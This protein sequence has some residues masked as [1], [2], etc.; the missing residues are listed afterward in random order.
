LPHTAPSELKGCTFAHWGQK[1]HKSGRV[2]GYYGYALHALIRVPDLLKDQRGPFTDKLAGPLLVQEFALTPASTD[3]VD[4]TLTMVDRV[5]ATGKKIR[6]LL[7]DRHYSYKS[8]DRWIAKLWRLGIRPVMDMRADGHGAFDYNGAM[9]IDGTPHCGVPA[10]LLEIQGPGV[11]ASQEDQ[12]LFHQA[13]DARAPYAMERIQTAWQH[14]DGITRFRCPARAGQVGCPR[15]AGSI[16]VA[17]DNNLPIVVPPATQTA[18]C[19]PDTATIKAIPQMKYQQEHYW[20]AHNW[21]ASFH[22]RTYVEGVFGNMKNHRTG[23]IHRGF[24]QFEG[25]PLVTLAVTAAV[26]AYNLRELESWY[27]RASVLN[28]PVYWDDLRN[29]DKIR[30]AETKKRL[31]AYAAHPLHQQTEHQHGFVM[32]TKAGQ[33]A[34]DSEH[35]ASPEAPEALAA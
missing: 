34:L 5:I 27:I 12:H 24:M 16:Q 21:R 6:D 8:Y 25:Q 10:G 19:T 20:G 1:T 26:I 17:Q 18:W 11:N 32:L 22:R 14:R 30:G 7:G 2:T 31:A 9:I 35:L 33:E 15:L 4:V 3:I 23:N 28:D 13:I 29:S